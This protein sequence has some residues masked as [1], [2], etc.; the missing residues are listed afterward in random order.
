MLDPRSAP[1]NLFESLPEL[2]LTL[3]F[4]LGCEQPLECAKVGCPEGLRSGDGNVRTNAD[5]FPVGTS[6]WI[7][8][9]ARRD[10][11]TEVLVH[12]PHS[13]GVGATASGVSHHLAPALGLQVVGKSPSLAY[14]TSR[15]R[16][17]LTA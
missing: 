12:S 3:R 17:R 2:R 6:A 4:A 9:A 14:V 10:P 5:P 16:S 15:C 11:D 7:D 8:R 13:T 1:T